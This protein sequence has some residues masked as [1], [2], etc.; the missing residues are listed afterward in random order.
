MDQ[1]R[2]EMRA[3]CDFAAANRDATAL[4][5]SA[6]YGLTIRD[7]DFKVREKIWLLDQITKVG[8]NPKLRPRLK[9]PYQV[10]NLFNEV[11]A[12]LKADGLSKILKVIHFSK[13]KNLYGIP[14]IVSIS[15]RDHSIDETRSIQ[16]LKKEWYRLLSQ[17]KKRT[18]WRVRMGPRK[19]T[20]RNWTEIL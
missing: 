11:N 14:H 2:K 16:N 15:N 19:V 18:E 5:V 20:F 9:G 6:L 13:L 1:Q 10:T 3:M 17:N 4:K 12:I 7:I 8:V